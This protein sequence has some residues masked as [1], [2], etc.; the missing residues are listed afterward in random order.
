MSNKIMLFHDKESMEM[1]YLK[2]REIELEAGSAVR[3]QDRVMRNMKSLS[4]RTK[5]WL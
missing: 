4:T 2:W 1:R 3:N 5:D